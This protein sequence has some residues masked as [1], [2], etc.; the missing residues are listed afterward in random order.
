MKYNV[1]LPFIVILLIPSCAGFYGNQNTG[2]YAAGFLGT[3]FEGYEQSAGTVKVAKG[4]Q[5][6][7]AQSAIRTAGT[8]GASALAAGVSETLS[9]NA[10][11]VSL[12]AQGVD[13]AATAGKFATQQLRI[14][15]QTKIK[16]F[17]PPVH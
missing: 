16:T 17:V 14:T 13:K 2:T 7:T 3:D 15:E 6:T 12:G 8:L 4:H 10:T 11:K 9:N 1:L 5:S